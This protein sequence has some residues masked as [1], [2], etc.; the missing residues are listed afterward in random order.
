MNSSIKLENA[1]QKNNANPTE[2]M[3]WINHNNIFYIEKCG[4]KVLE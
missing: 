4:Y 1:K 3:R 2:K